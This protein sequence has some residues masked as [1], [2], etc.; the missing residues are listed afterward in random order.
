MNTPE[1]LFREEAVEHHLRRRVPGDVLRLRGN[2]IRRAFWVLV[3]LGAGG[4]LLGL[5]TSVDQ[6]VSGP[7]EVVRQGELIARFPGRYLGDISA[8]M[9]VVL[10][11]GGGSI[12]FVVEEVREE[13]G[14]VVVAARWSGSGPQAETGARG[15]AEVTVRESLLLSLIPGTRYFGPP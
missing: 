8:G 2:W 10:N 12:P 9:T 3:V 15:T 4:M 1:S 13:N 11:E 14:H 6:V 5:R 7:G